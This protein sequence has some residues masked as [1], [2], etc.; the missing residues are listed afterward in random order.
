MSEELKVKALHMGP[1]ECAVDLGDGSERGEYVDQDYILQ[2]L[3]RPHRAVN[4]MYC[5]GSKLL[6]SMT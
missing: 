1:A 5:V 3:G 4:L 2:K 6:K